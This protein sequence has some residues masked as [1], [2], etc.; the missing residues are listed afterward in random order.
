MER[1]GKINENPADSIL[2]TVYS[3][4]KTLVA[5]D[6]PGLPIRFTIEVIRKFRENVWDVKSDG[7][8]FMFVMLAYP[9]IYQSLNLLS[10]AL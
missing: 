4:L 1:Y 10:V 8:I 2:E 6:L 5:M 3:W 7:Q 9:F